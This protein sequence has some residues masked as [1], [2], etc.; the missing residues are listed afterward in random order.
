M[1]KEGLIQWLMI[2]IGA[3]VAWQVMLPWGIFA[4]QMVPP[5]RYPAILLMVLVIV[6]PVLLGTLVW[7][8][9]NKIVE[10]LRGDRR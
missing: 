7:F 3:L 1:L 8:L 10:H 2:G 4:N 9:L 5:G 6:P